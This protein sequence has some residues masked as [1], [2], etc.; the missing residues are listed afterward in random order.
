MM[1]SPHLN[2]RD[3]VRGGLLS[4]RGKGYSRN[5]ITVLGRQYFVVDTHQRRLPNGFLG[6]VNRCK[7]L[8]PYHSRTVWLIF[9][10]QA[11]FHPILTTT[12]EKTETQRRFHDL[13]KVTQQQVQNQG[14]NSVPLKQSHSVGCLPFACSVVS[15]YQVLGAVLSSDRK[16]Y[17]WK[18]GAV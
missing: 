15:G 3:E 12:F 2:H 11:L 4:R 7:G 9:V 13:P 14:P 8:Y 6:E 18:P 10:Q 17:S 5:Q 1:G 16:C